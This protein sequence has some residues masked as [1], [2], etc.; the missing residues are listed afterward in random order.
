MATTTVIVPG[1][2]L[3]RLEGVR[4]AFA[5]IGLDNIIIGT[6]AEISNE[7]KA[8]QL[9]APPPS[10]EELFAQLFRPQQAPGLNEK[11]WV[12]SKRTLTIKTFLLL[13]EEGYTLFRIDLTSLR[14]SY[15]IRVD[16]AW[17]YLGARTSVKKIG[18][19]RSG[20]QEDEYY[21]RSMSLEELKKWL[22]LMFGGPYVHR[23]LNSILE[24][25]D[26]R[27]DPRSKYQLLESNLFSYLKW[28]GT[29]PQ[30]GT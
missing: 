6:Y 5:D 12:S 19:A 27:G 28:D 22:S 26:H 7:G 30:S 17:V 24:T 4:Q 2:H 23:R 11:C 13:V 1:T 18:S 14:A 21:C 25:R 3:N 10:F 9:S 20:W 8:D 15:Y 29:C 16:Q